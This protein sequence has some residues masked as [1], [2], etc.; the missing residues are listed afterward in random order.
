MKT[1]SNYIDS[2]YIWLVDIV[3]VSARH[4]DR[5]LADSS[6]RVCHD[7]PPRPESDRESPYIPGQQFYG[8]M[9]PRSEDEN[10]LY[11]EEALRLRERL[12]R[13]QNRMKKPG[14]LPRKSTNKS[15]TDL[16][17]MPS[18]LGYEIVP[19]AASD[20]DV[21]SDLQTTNGEGEGVEVIFE[22][23]LDIAR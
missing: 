3:L 5:P 18:S 23:P 10:K 11:Q 13:L 20:E 1:D 9:I 4:Y 22:Q 19:T 15:A 16:M 2:N 17:N 21:I 8:A 7:A 6:A 12:V 14:S